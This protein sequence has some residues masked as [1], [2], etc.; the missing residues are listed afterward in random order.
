MRLGLGL[1]HLYQRMLFQEPIHLAW[2]KY[3]V[4]AL[5]DVEGT[6]CIMHHDIKDVVPNAI[7]RV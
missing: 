7:G 6:S 2:W 1:T 4:L 5:A 3:A